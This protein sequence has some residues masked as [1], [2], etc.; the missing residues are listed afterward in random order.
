[1]GESH[2]NTRDGTD[3]GIGGSG[4]RRRSRV[5][6]DH[7]CLDVRD[8]VSSKSTDGKTMVFK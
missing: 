6:R 3:D 1:M 2:E 5:W 7:V 8:M 4:Q